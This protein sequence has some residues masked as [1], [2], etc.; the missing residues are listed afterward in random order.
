MAVA[1]VMSVVV[2]MVVTMIVTVVVSVIVSSVIVTVVMSVIMSVIVCA[3]VVSVSTT[4]FT[5]RMVMLTTEMVMAFA[6][7]QNLNED[8]VEAEGKDCDD[9]HV[10]AD[11]LSRFHES[12]SSFS[13]EPDSHNPDGGNGNKCSDN[14]GAS[15][16]I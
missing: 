2:T 12:H 10:F 15:P 14:F 5:R 3:V 4:A 11:N 9:Q 16:T 8:Q 1:V 6:R 13:E 7:V